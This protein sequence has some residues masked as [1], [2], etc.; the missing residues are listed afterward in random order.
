MT[1]IT[2]WIEVLKT[3]KIQV[4]RR[5]HGFMS[6]CYGVNLVADVLLAAV[7]S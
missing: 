3:V 1:E 5:K 2:S 7:A 4:K 6:W